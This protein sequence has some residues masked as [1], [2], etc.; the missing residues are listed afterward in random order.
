MLEAL[1]ITVE[2]TRERATIRGLLPAE[3]PE[4][5]TIEQTSA[6]MFND[7]QIASVPFALVVVLYSAS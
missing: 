7:S 4:F 6:C 5:I 3:V 1:Q 2:A